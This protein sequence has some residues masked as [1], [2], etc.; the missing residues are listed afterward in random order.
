MIKQKKI[1][2]MFLTTQREIASGELLRAIEYYSTYCESEYSFDLKIFLD[3]RDTIDN[4]QVEEIEKRVKVLPHVD[5]FEIVNNKIPERL[6]IVLPSTNDTF[7][8]NKFYLGRTHGINQHFHESMNHMFS[9]DYEN[10]LLLEADTKPVD[11]R[12]LNVIIDKCEASTFTILGSTY[13]GVA[14]ED[15]MKKYYGPHLNGVAIYKN[16]KTCKDII[17]LSIEYIK[18][19]LKHDTD[20][21]YQSII[22]YDVALYLYCKDEDLL[23]HLTDTEIIT[24]VSSYREDW[25]NANVFIKQYPD[26][27]IIHK[28]NLYK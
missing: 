17:N 12:W 28:K 9:C 10:F 19:E 27:V 16:S 23:K 13:K 8:L 22:N 24:N 3:S 25:M 7:D 5:N 11:K 14:R 15:E 20:K 18:T 1:C 26:T 21:K 4:K 2:V 6:N